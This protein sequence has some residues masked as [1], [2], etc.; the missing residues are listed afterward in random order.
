MKRHAY[1]IIAHQHFDLLQRLM[2]ALD[3]KSADFYIHIDRRVR[4]LNAEQLSSCVKKSRARVFQRYKITWGADTQVRCEMLL[5]EQAARGNYDY[6]HLLSGVD[7]PLKTSGEIES[8]FEDR[9]ESFIEVK[10]E[11]DATG[12]M[13]RARYYYPLQNL[14][15][16]PVRHAGFVRGVLDQISYELVKVQRAL[17]LDRT[18]NAP[19]AYCRGG[20]WFS[21]THDL[22]SY[23]LENKK[24]VKRFF[25]HAMTSDEM[26][27]QCLACAS[28]YKDR[29]ERDNLRL[30]DWQRAEHDGCSPHTFT[31]QDLPMLLS[32][33]KLWARKFD[34]NVDR[35]VIDALYARIERSDVE[36]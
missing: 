12:T 6:Y 7:I 3:S 32:S 10:E 36:A 16:R 15:G 33:D 8:F 17:G 4:G 35:E 26:F 22:A 29:I 19:F 13:D 20:N 30:I 27:L 25:Y 1:L 2:K 31:M 14:I 34:P 28:P 24:L 11:R 21:I 5:L 18:K 23:V 9:G